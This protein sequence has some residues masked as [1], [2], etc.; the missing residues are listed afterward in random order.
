MELAD[1]IMLEAK[2]EYEQDC[3]V[4]VDIYAVIASSMSF[5]SH[6]YSRKEEWIRYI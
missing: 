4:P 5:L 2:M 6:E 1:K 3:R